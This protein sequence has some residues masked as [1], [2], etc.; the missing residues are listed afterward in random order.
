M[1][2]IFS[3]AFWP[4][5]CLLCRIG[6]LDLLPIFWLGC[7]FFWYWAAW[8]VCIF[9]RLIPCQL[10]HLHHPHSLEICFFSTSMAKSIFIVSTAG[11]FWFFFFKVFSLKIKSTSSNCKIEKKLGISSV[12]C[13]TENKTF[14]SIRSTLPKSHSY[15]VTD[16]F[17]DLQPAD[18]STITECC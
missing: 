9:W 7:L 3:C 13:L 18:P 12:P 11:G 10:L 2:S 6:Y 4:S 8:A 14:A 5:V 1:L 15:L 16:R 17:F